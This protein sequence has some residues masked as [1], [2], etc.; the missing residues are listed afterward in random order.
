MEENRLELM[1]KEDYSI[2]E[3][4]K[5]SERLDQIIIEKIKG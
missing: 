2:D 4:L 5:E 1:I 3:I